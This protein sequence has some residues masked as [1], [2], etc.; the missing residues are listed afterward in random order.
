MKLSICIPSL[1]ARR[2][3]LVRL[4]A[5]LDQPRAD[6]TEILIAI[7]GGEQILGAKR[8][9]LVKSAIGEY[10]IWIDDDD[11]VDSTYIDKILTAIEATRADAI[12]LLGMRIDTMGRVKPQPFG[13]RKM[14][15]GIEYDEAGTLWRSPGHLCAVRSEIVRAVPFIE[16]NTAED[17]VWCEAVQPRLQT[18]ALASDQVLYHYLWDSRKTYR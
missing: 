14:G 4:L 5:A 11:M 2:N 7:D 12:A 15:L 3:L 6:E 1:H 16:R 13:Y 10:I 9:S 17:L 8:N 18:V